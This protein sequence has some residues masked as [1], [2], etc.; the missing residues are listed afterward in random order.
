MLS[1]RI[2]FVR[3]PQHVA[4]ELLT[5]PLLVELH[6]ATVRALRVV[7]HDGEL[8]DQ[9]LVLWGHR[10]P[11]ASG[12]QA[13]GIEHDVTTLAEHGNG[14]AAGHVPVVVMVLKKPLDPTAVRPPVFVQPRAHHA[15]IRK[16]RHIPAKLAQQ[17]R[18]VPGM[19][20][21][22]IA[23]PVQVPKAEFRV[24]RPRQAFE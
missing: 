8:D 18:D 12:H 4:A 9:R 22:P 14:L 10:S 23:P 24:V 16:A 3:A 15:R 20:P 5:R 11:V 21:L 2:E 7:G 6:E 19:A 17:W 13:K 1:P